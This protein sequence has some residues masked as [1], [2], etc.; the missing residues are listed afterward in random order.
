MEKKGSVTIPVF[1]CIFRGSDSVVS[2]TREFDDAMYAS[3]PNLYAVCVAE[4]HGSVKK[5]VAGFLIKTT[6]THHD[7][8]F[9]AALTA[10]LTSS[11]NLH[12]FAG[13]HTSFLPARLS[14][15]DPSPLSEQE[16]LKIMINQYLKHSVGGYA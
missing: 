15:P 13:P 8:D 3:L 1:E 16:F 14:M 7:D 5:V 11:E 6:F 10:T 9:R 4:T 12:G 2:F